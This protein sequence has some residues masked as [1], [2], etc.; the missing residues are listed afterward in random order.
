MKSKWFR[1]GIDNQIHIAMNLPDSAIELLP[2]FSGLLAD[3]TPA[4]REGAIGGPLVHVYAFTSEDDY[5]KD[6][7]DRCQNS[8]G[9]AYPPP[10]C[11]ADWVRNVAPQKN[12]Y[13]QE[14]LKFDRKY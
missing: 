13:R 7:T 9:L 2:A 14:P 5:L 4:E 8:L 12:M 6:L 11:T 10:E 3:D 1:G